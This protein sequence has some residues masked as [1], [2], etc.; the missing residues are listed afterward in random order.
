MT[1]SSSQQLDLLWKK[2]GHGVAKTDTSVFKDATNESIS[3]SPFIPSNRIWSQSFL[4]PSVLPAASSALVEVHSD[5]LSNSVACT[6]DITASDNRTWLTGL[7]DW[8]PIQFGSTYLVKIWLDS[9]TSTTPQTTGTQLFSAG[10]DNNDEWFFDYEAG[11]L[12]FIGDN[13]PPV[14]F[15]GKKIFIT[16][17]RYIGP[18]GLGTFGNIS[19]NGDTITSLGN[20]TLV[21]APGYVVNV[22]GAPISNVGY[23]TDANAAATTQ[24][25]IDTIALLHSN[26]I[27][28][29]DSIVRLSDPTGNA[30]TFSITLDGQVISTVTNSSATFANI[31]M[32]GSTISSLGDLVLQPAAANV[33]VVNATTAFRVP[34][35][36]TLERP[37]YLAAGEIRF[38]TTTSQLE[39][40][41]GYD[42]INAQAQLTSQVIN[43][44]GIATQFTLN[45]AT[46]AYNV[47]VM[48]NGVVSAPIEAYDILGTQITFIEAP[49]IGDRIEIRFLSEAVAAVDELSARVIVNP[50]AVSVGTVLTQIDTFDVSLFSAAKYV[51]VVSTNDGNV[52]SSELSVVQNGTNAAIVRYNDVV[53]G[54]TVTVTYSVTINAGQCVL[55][56]VCNTATNSLKLQR[57]YT[58]I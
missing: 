24:F 46:S 12:N 44:D 55:S 43:G 28:Q 47:F 23:S 26:I 35:G 39:W 14:S 13:L 27:Y 41:N 3:S 11:I 45:Q 36:T 6:M 21:P 40:Y 33:V 2:L 7:G 16:G 53:T 37:A 51:S 56:A 54:G 38:N 1:V 5:A 22:S 29:G 9:N 18:T 58:T 25:V 4:I 49:K 32:S 10:S 52:Q 34:S 31:T 8:I 50:L 19:V 48:I 17:A 15:T 42:W 20:I 30:A 57:A